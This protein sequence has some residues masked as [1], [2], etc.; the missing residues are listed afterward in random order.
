VILISG[1]IEDV[2]LMM[3]V[4]MTALLLG[5]VFGLVVVT[6]IV[7]EIVGFEFAVEYNNLWQIRPLPLLL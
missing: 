6:V 1:A 4:V 3:V 5:A 7:V 2:V